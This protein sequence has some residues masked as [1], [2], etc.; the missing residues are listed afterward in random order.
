M[1]VSVFVAVFNTVLLLP[2]CMSFFGPPICCCS[3]RRNRSVTNYC[4][5]SV[6]TVC[7]TVFFLSTVCVVALSIR[8]LLSKTLLEHTRLTKSLWN[9]HW[10]EFCC[11][12]ANLWSETFP[13]LQFTQ[14]VYNLVSVSRANCICA[15]GTDCYGACRTF[16]GRGVPRNPPRWSLVLFFSF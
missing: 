12:S 13:A 14:T 5:C 11:F 15:R 10:K 16:S 7:K 8:I 1:C 9:S 4:V 6:V 2:S 3:S